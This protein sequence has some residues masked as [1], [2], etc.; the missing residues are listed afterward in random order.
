MATIT[1]SHFDNEKPT[2]DWYDNN[3]YVYDDWDY[4]TDD[5]KQFFV[6][7]VDSIKNCETRWGNIRYYVLPCDLTEKGWKIF[8]LDDSSDRAE[9]LDEK[10][11][12]F[13][14]KEALWF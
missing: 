12:N 5:F 14:K 10:Y 2:F 11:R 13:I 9:Y 1:L 4:H 8:G 3:I 6:N 7:G